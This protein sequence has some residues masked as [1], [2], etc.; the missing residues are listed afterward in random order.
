M[1][2]CAITRHGAQCV[3]VCVCVRAQTWEVGRGTSYVMRGALL[4]EISRGATPPPFQRNNGA[5]YRTRFGGS[6][7][8]QRTVRR[9]FS[10]GTRH[11]PVAINYAR[12][13]FN[14]LIGLDVV[15]TA[16]KRKSGRRRWVGKAGGGEGM[17]KPCPS[18]IF[19]RTQHNPAFA[20]E[21][22]LPFLL[23]ACQ[24]VCAVLID[25]QR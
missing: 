12:R 23:L 2:A 10:S 4:R 6:F 5:L 20:E 8:I 9:S 21:A 22:S 13:T 15:K 16:V 24:Q 18:A 7:A 1:H 25:A 11:S 17:E 14:H 3:C 19:G